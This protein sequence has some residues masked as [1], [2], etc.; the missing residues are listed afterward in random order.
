M[1]KDCTKEY[2]N[3]LEFLIVFK[4]M[5]SACFI[6]IWKVESRKMTIFQYDFEA[7]YSIVQYFSNF[8]C[9]LSLWFGLAAIDV[10]KIFKNVFILSKLF[11]VKF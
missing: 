2:F 9:I 8:G 1:Q 5:D 4:E 6:S 11:L 7:K 10:Y 3:V